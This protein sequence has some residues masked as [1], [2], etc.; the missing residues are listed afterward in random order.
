[1]NYFNIDACKYDFSSDSVDIITLVYDYS[2]SMDTYEADMLKANKAF[3]A[4][5]SKFEEK[6][7]VA[8]AKGRFNDNFDMT[9][10]DSVSQ[11]DTSYSAN[12]GTA[13]YYAIVESAKKTIEYYNEKE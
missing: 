10:F 2:G 11:F 7:S 13:L 4:D 9:S 1:M 6:G 8:I 3:H 5:F 12:G